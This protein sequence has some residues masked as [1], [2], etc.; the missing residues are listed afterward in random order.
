VTSDWPWPKRKKPDEDIVYHYTT[1]PGRNRGIVLIINNVEFPDR[2]RNRDSSKE[3]GKK[4]I[5]AFEKYRYKVTAKLNL[6]ADS[7]KKA[8]EK[9]VKEDVTRDHDSFI[10]CILSHGSPA[11]IEG[12]DGTPVTVT[13]LAN[14]V[15][16]DMLLGKPKILIF[17]ACRGDGMPERMVSDLS[18][19][20]REE[21]EVIVSDGRIELPPEAD[22][23]FA[24]STVD[25]NRALRG[26]D[27]GSHYIT[28]LSNAIIDYGSK[29]SIE[30]ILLVVNHKVAGEPK[31]VTKDGK[32]YRYHQMPEI[33]STLRGCFY[34]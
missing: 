32:T 23:L 7:M 34:F 5:K 6:K 26:E 12:V 31:K 33:R 11:G 8:I 24:F 15:N 19:P 9:A 17:Q 14:I 20:S 22:F 4:L 10:C 3:D 13:E 2:R 1:N 18:I 25:N 27:S 21:E 29:L 16:C 30:K 28:A